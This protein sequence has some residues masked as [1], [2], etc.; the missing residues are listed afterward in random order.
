MTPDEIRLERERLGVPDAGLMRRAWI[1]YQLQRQGWS[2][3]RIA[4][5]TKASES[6]V[7]VLYLGHRPAGDKAGRVRELTAEVLGMPEDVL[8]PEA[9]EDAARRAEEAARR[10]DEEPTREETKRE[11]ARLRKQRQRKRARL[12]KR[13]GKRALKALKKPKRRARV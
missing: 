12:A 13:R 8:F 10:A 11:Q 6:T 4:R 3:A 1:R 9:R 5:A 7:S 2:Q